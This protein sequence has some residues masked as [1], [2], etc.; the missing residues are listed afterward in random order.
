MSYLAGA[1]CRI[2]FTGST[3][4][5]VIT[6]YIGSI[7]ETDPKYVAVLFSGDEIFMD[8]DDPATNEGTVFSS[9]I[10]CVHPDTM[11]STDK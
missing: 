10:C 8:I 5:D 4:A 2:T 9:E 1:C 7:T 3:D 11:V 6:V